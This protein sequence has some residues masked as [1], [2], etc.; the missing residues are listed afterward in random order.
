M[1]R[2]WLLGLLSFN[3]GF[4]DTAGFLGL[5]GLFVAHVTG[6]F[7]TLG[8]AIAFGTKGVLAKLIALPE[9][10]IVI[11]LARLVGATLR[12]RHWPVMKILLAV[13]ALFLLS[14]F[15]PAVTLGRSRIATARRRC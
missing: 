5:Q 2:I 11:A 4:G 12:A 15:V 13:K 3:G 14:F 6:N 1:K 10:I 9:F 7:V 8:A